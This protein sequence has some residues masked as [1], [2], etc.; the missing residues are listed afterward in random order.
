MHDQKGAISTPPWPTE[1]PVVCIIICQRLISFST[2]SIGSDE[3]F[4]SARLGSFSL[5]RDEV[6]AMQRL[7]AAAHR[8]DDVKGEVF[9]SQQ[10]R[11]EYGRD[12]VNCEALH[13]CTE[14]VETR[15][16]KNQQIVRG[17]QAVQT[18]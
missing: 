2:E 7:D 14:G 1:W 15:E 13:I 10:W 8:P 4:I 11:L 9:L 6:K 16:T 18:F 3:S 5:H 17:S 12:K